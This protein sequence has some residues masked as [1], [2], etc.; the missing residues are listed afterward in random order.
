MVE[1]TIIG[2]FSGAS[3]IVELVMAH[4][5]TIPGTCSII[6]VI[7]TAAVETVAVSEVLLKVLLLQGGGNVSVRIFL[8]SGNSLVLALRFHFVEAWNSGFSGFRFSPSEDSLSSLSHSLPSKMMVLFASISS[9]NSSMH[10]FGL[11]T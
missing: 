7:W 9:A 4:S 6:I 2:G 11:S 10:S 8:F 1:E 3:V 5:S